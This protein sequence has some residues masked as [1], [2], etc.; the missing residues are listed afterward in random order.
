MVKIVDSL[1][2]SLINEEN[3]YDSH[4]IPGDYD[5]KRNLLRA[6]LNIRPPSH[7]EKSFLK[8]IDR[9]LQ[10]ELR[11]RKIVAPDELYSIS[12]Q[13]SNKD[14]KNINTLFL[15]KGD[16]TCLMAD[17]IV[18]A[19]NDR[20]LGCFQPL[21]NC[22]DN[23]IH[24]A[25]GPLLREDCK[26]IMDI[27]GTRELT[28]DA[29][30]TRAYNLPSRYVIHTVGPIITEREVRDFQKNQLASCYTSCLSLAA[31]IKEIK[32]I[33]FPCISTGVYNFPQG[34]AAEIAVKTVD[35]WLETHKHGFTHIIFDVF[36]EEDLSC[37]ARIFR[38]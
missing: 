15:W 10:N 2:Y 37:Y 16:I 38:G 26:I 19:A 23:V 20:M 3:L 7:M 6:L 4:Q 29:K 17:A 21:H 5:G 9:L 30:I 35:E 1:L 25:A 31:Q 32:S 13:F 14:I 33:A 27:Q 24:S 18:N 12:N 22:I 36:L 34:L 8:N 28:G 11:D